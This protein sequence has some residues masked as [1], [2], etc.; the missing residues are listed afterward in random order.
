[1]PKTL[2]IDDDPETEAMFAACQALEG[3]G[4]FLFAVTDEEAMGRWCSDD[5][6]YIMQ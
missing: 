6:H 3:L 1:M 4:E 5:S 2:D